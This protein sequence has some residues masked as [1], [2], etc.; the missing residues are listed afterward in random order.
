MLAIGLQSLLVAQ[1]VWLDDTGDILGMMGGVM[2][3]LCTDQSENS[4]RLSVAASLQP[5]SKS[6]FGFVLVIVI[7]CVRIRMLK[8][9]KLN[10]EGSNPFGRSCRK[11]GWQFSIGASCGAR[12]LK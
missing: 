6:C 10:V 8:L 9:S 5:V 7:G 1:S 2:H 12:D 3:K 11:P 4:R